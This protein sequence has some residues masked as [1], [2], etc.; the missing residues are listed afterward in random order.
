MTTT[1]TS[2]LAY[3]EINEEGTSRNQKDRILDMVNRDNTGNG[4]SLREISA[5]TGI[6]INAVSGRVNDLKNERKLKTINKRKCSLSKR[7]ISP[8]MLTTSQDKKDLEDEDKLKL[9]LR[10]YGYKEVSINV[11]SNNQKS[12]R[13]GYYGYIKPADLDKIHINC[14]IRLKE[15]NIWDDDCGNKYWYEIK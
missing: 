3:K 9:L 15:A 8:V 12:V 5:F 14:D 6:E 4:M 2:R 11:N 10:M 1:Q 7:L 13:I